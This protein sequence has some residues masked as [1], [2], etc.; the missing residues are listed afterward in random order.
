M[1]IQKTS[2]S[3]HFHHISPPLLQ[4]KR[5][6]SE[7]QKFL[8]E[9][10]LNAQRSIQK[11]MQKSEVKIV[12][13]NHQLIPK[14]K[15]NIQL[16]KKVIK[17]KQ[18]SLPYLKLDEKLYYDKW[19]IPYDQRYIPKVNLAQEQYQE[20]KDPNHFYKNMHVRTAQYNPFEK[21]LPKDLERNIEYKHR[22]DILKEMLK[23][24]KMIYEFRKSLEQ[25]QQ[26]IPQFIK[27]IIEDKKNPIQK[28]Q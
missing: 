2:F 15:M 7:G 3:T 28:Q 20:A 23:G 5:M 11:R 17:T 9:L 6:K 21:D 25:N 14:Q 12:E 24:Q 26:R 4:T 8:T 22:S 18:P 16:R 1:E 27:K 13:T 19:Y 10:D